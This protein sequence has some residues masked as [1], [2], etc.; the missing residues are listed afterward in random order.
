VRLPA[1]GDAAAETLDAML[2]RGPP[3]L[4]VDDVDLL[5]IGPLAERIER[6]LVEH[7]SV[8]QVIALAG[9][10]DVLAA[11]F[12]GPVAVARRRRLGLLLRPESRHDGDLFGIR[13]PSE[14]T[15]GSGPPGRG[16]LISGSDATEVQVAL[17]D[18]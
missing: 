1:D 18:V 5:P 4:L 15:A 3:H 11:T 13:L 6:W 8:Q 10:T 9:A 14:A 12:R 16:W 17:P 2:D 7:A